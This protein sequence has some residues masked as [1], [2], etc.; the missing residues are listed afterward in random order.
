MTTETCTSLYTTDF[1]FALTPFFHQ[2]HILM[3]EILYFPFWRVEE[4]VFFFQ[5]IHA[6]VQQCSTTDSGRREAQLRADLC[7][8]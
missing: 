7:P 5:K 3:N 8:V 2:S 4:F 6:M 1:V